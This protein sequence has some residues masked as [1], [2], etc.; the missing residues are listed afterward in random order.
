MILRYLFYFFY[1]NFLHLLRSHVTAALSGGESRSKRVKG[2]C[3]DLAG[4]GTRPDAGFRFTG[5]SFSGAKTAQSG[6]IAIANVVSKLNLQFH[7]ANQV[8]GK[9]YRTARSL[10][11]MP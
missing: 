9:S 5:T 1:S 10:G 6:A 7:M 8:G 2:C 4:L 3:L 11:G